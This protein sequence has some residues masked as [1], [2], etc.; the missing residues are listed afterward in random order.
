[1][2]W[3]VEWHGDLLAYTQVP[4]P[5]TLHTALAR[6]LELLAG[7][8]PG[9]VFSA[10]PS[11]LCLCL[12]GMKPNSSPACPVLYISYIPCKL[13]TVLTLLVRKLVL[14]RESVLFKRHTDTT[15]GAGAGALVISSSDPPVAPIFRDEAS[16]SRGRIQWHSS[17]FSP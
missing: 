11:A 6:S 2:G 16:Q 13:D 1:M 17:E 3:A 4:S 8:R 15:W 7:N 5:I 10:V 14:Q 9:A 12:N